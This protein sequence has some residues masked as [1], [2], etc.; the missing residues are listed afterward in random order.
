MPSLRK[1]DTGHFDGV[2]GARQHIVEGE[3]FCEEPREESEREGEEG[4]EKEKYKKTG[5]KFSFTKIAT[6]WEKRRGG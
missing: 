6:W 2:L 4:K 3:R 5:S 1:T